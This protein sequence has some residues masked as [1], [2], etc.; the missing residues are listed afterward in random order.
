MGPTQVCSDVIFIPDMFS[1]GSRYDE[2]FS[3]ST[4]EALFICHKMK[5]FFVRCSFGFVM[6]PS[7][8]LSLSLLPLLNRTFIWSEI[9]VTA[10]LWWLS[11]PY[12]E[13]WRECFLRR[14]QPA[15]SPAPA[16]YMLRSRQCSS[17]PVT[18][19]YLTFLSFCLLSLHTSACLIFFYVSW[20]GSY[21][22]V[23]F[24]FPDVFGGGDCNFGWLATSKKRI[25]SCYLGSFYAQEARQ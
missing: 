7:L 10:A 13:E 17:D 2:T 8:C 20:S 1:L 25:L 22:L 21:P 3:H 9:T 18:A 12:K 4:D 24:V 19:A 16:Y 23:S 5:N 15:A 11:I 14:V 6:M